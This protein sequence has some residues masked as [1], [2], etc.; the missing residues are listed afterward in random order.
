M[1]SVFMHCNMI[2]C[3]LSLAV[4]HGLLSP[5]Q[6]SILHFANHVLQNFTNYSSILVSFP[7]VCP[8]M[9]ARTLNLGSSDSDHQALIDDLLSS[10][11]SVAPAQILVSEETLRE[12]NT[13]D[14]REDAYFLFL[15]LCESLETVQQEENNVDF[16]EMYF[17]YIEIVLE[18]QIK[19]IMEKPSCNLRGKYILILPMCGL[20]EGKHLALRIIQKWWSLSRMTHFIVVVPNT[21]TSGSTRIYPVL[22]IYTWFPYENNCGV[23]NDVVLLNQWLPKNGGQLSNHTNLFLYKTIRNYYGCNLTVIPGGPEPFVIVDKVKTGSNNSVEPSNVQGISMYI[24]ESFAKWYNFSIYYLPHVIIADT[25]NILH[26][27][28]IFGAGIPDFTSALVPLSTVPWALSELSLP[29]LQ[30]SAIFAIPCPKRLGKLS[31]V[32]AIFSTYTWLS[33]AVVLL[34]SGVV[35]FLQAKWKTTEIKLY[36]KMTECLSCVWAILL[37]VSVPQ[38]PKSLNSRLF[39]LLYVCYSLAISVVFQAFFVTYLVEPR[40]EKNFKT[41]S[42][43]RENGVKYGFYDFA[44]F[45]LGF[46][47]F[48]EQKRLEGIQCKSVVECVEGV[49]AHQNMTALSTKYIARYIAYKRGVEDIDSIMCFL[50]EML[51]SCLF[52]CIAVQKGSP[53]LPILNEHITGNQEGGLQDYYWTQLKHSVHLRTE[54]KTE[55]MYFAFSISHMGPIFGL[56]CAGYIISLIIF[57]I[58]I[59]VS[60]YKERF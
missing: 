48:K 20:Y 19:Q 53:L 14:L 52:L 47:G 21:C 26:G 57:G 12:E 24:I 43:L 15:Y 16:T 28:E 60:S 51:F 18:D 9:P 39:F 36:R 33:I 25:K 44:E 7:N 3:F 17:N 2:V 4:V 30:E 38:M 1:T 32:A 23:V 35:M 40:Y 11:S 55:E 22:D 59:I 49:V 13:F 56:L 37:G 58:E 29:V 46:M 6:E 10:L 5:L 42:D 31:T 54:L 45:L 41:F 27:V 8:Q 34:M 50:D